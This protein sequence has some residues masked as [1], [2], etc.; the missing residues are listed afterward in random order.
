MKLLKN[1]RQF[2]INDKELEKIK[3]R[4]NCWKRREHDW[5]ISINPP[6]S[7]IAKCKDCGLTRKYPYK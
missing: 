2:F 6:Y 5:V 7:V 1:L 3:A 4:I